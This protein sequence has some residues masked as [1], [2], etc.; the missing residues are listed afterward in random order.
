M[1]ILVT[2]GMGFIGSNL[3][4][5]LLED[6]HKVIAF[7]NL[8]TGKHSNI[9]EFQDNPNFRFIEGDVR[10]CEDFWHIMKGIDYIFHLAAVPS[11]QRSVNNPFYSNEV[12][13]EGT[14][15][16]LDAARAFKIKRL[17]YA[18]SSSCAELLSPYALTKFA[19]EK[20]CQ[21][22]N[23]FYGI[24]T[25]SLRYFN[26]FGKNQSADSDY[27]AVIPKFIKL[28]KEDKR[29]IIYGDGYQSRDFTHVSNVVNAN[30]LAMKAKGVT[31]KVF[32][33]GCGTAINLRTLV[34]TINELLGKD[35]KPIY[36]DRKKGDINYSCAD[37]D[38]TKTFLNYEPRVRF[39]E[40]LERLIN[41]TQ[42]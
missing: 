12:N 17:I 28:M 10:K 15:N 4:K 31:G 35:I 8:S 25:I 23:D 20:Y 9:A 1:N 39:Q 16:I 11:I 21:L 30:I 32:N 29:P 19:G 7:D 18:S 41:E 40:G 24:E 42:R 26:V 36:T 6:N 5:R 27:S 33:V 2:G 38:R 3:V 13:I 14:L 37:I 34:K 22:Y